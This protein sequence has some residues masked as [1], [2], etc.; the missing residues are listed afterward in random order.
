MATQGTLFFKESSWEILGKEYFKTQKALKN[1]ARAQG[2]GFVAI[3]PVEEQVLP[4]VMNGGCAVSKIYGSQRMES[5]KFFDTPRIRAHSLCHNCDG[6]CDVCHRAARMGSRKLAPQPVDEF[7][8]EVGDLDWRDNQSLSEQ[9]HDYNSQTGDYGHVPDEEPSVSTL[10]APGERVDFIELERRMLQQDEIL[11]EASR[12]REER[13]RAT[14]VPLAVLISR[15]EMGESLS[16][17]EEIVLQEGLE[18]VRDEANAA[19]EFHQCGWFTS[20]RYPELRKKTP[21]CNL[22]AKWRQ[23]GDGVWPSRKTQDVSVMN[24]NILIRSTEKVVSD[25]KLVIQGCR[26][27]Y[28][29]HLLDHLVHEFMYQMSGGIMPWD[30][31][32]KSF[33]WEDHMD[34]LKD[35]LVDLDSIGWFGTVREVEELVTNIFNSVSKTEKKDAVTQLTSFLQGFRAAKGLKNPPTK[36]DQK[37]IADWLDGQLQS[38]RLPYSDKFWTPKK[39]KTPAVCMGCWLQRKGVC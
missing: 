9:E 20:M 28:R 14:H 38:F 1:F 19:Q 12:K 37:M 26:N 31:V 18:Q 17:E 24:A 27:I 7:E 15:K 16:P 11:A 5:Y 35:P 10:F 3:N 8:S 4:Q 22:C 2:F 33:M 13:V 30:V 39:F 29:S 34:R 32:P 25:A 21:R 6:S 23:A 36:S